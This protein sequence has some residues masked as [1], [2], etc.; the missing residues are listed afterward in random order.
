VITIVACRKTW[1]TQTPAPNLPGI[2]DRARL[3]TY[4]PSPCSPASGQTVP[5]LDPRAYSVSPFTTHLVATACRTR[6]CAPRTPRT[7]E[8][9]KPRPDQSAESSTNETARPLRH[10]RLISEDNLE[11]GTRAR[12]IGR[13][14][15]PAQETAPAA[16]HL[17]AY[18]D[19][20]PPRLRPRGQV[21]FAAPFGPRGQGYLWASRRLS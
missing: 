15:T 12:Q 6:G 8:Q 16:F 19:E 11:G 10:R 2:S 17:T 21:R 13:Q 18:R 4:R 9:D 3:D 14:T 20:R 5:V 7:V 1:Q